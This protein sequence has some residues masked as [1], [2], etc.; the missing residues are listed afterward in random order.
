[1]NFTASIGAQLDSDDGE[2]GFDGRSKIGFTY[3]DLFKMLLC[4]IL[5]YKMFGF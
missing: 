2:G 3:V 1:M 4:D 5:Y